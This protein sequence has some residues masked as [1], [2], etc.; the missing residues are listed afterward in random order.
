MNS[1]VEVVQNSRVLPFQR[2]TFSVPSSRCTIDST[3]IIADCNLPIIA[4]FSFP[5][6][7]SR[8]GGVYSSHFRFPVN[9]QKWAGFASSVHRVPRA[10]RASSSLNWCACSLVACVKSKD[11]HPPRCPA[12]PSFRH[13]HV[14]GCSAHDPVRAVSIRQDQ[15]G[16][17]A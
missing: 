2:G 1:S 15:D 4:D 14:L 12:V 11:V 13:P 17:G 9:I 3:V 6:G 8:S 16:R 10:V 5:F 7:E